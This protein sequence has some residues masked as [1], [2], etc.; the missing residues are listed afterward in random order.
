MYSYIQ[1][2]CPIIHTDTCMRIHVHAC[3]HT[4]V[5][6]SLRSS[7]FAPISSFKLLTFHF[8]LLTFHFSLMFPLFTRLS[9]DGVRD[10][11][12]TRDSS[13]TFS[14]LQLAPPT[15]I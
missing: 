3:M 9:P 14:N 8:K 13:F 10:L 7:A 5:Y 12:V 2:H 6:I 11:S 4:Y 15:S 1:A